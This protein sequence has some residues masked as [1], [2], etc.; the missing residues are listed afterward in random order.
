MEMSVLKKKKTRTKKQRQNQPTKHTRTAPNQTNI[1]KYT[2]KEFLKG[3]ASANYALEKSSFK[4][5]S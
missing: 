4:E 5:G 2:W 3:K 1:K